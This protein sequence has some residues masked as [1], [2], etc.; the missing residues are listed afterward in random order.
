VLPPF[1]IPAVRNLRREPEKPGVL[2]FRGLYRWLRASGVN[3]ESPLYIFRKE[4]GSIIYELTDSYDR[5]ADFL[6]NDPRIAREH[7]VG[8]RRRLEVEVPG[9][10]DAA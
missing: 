5:A 2:L 7:Y 8:S 3:V 9:L 1:V 4:A 10:D 6:R